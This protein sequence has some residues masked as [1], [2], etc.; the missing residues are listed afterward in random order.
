MRF[1]HSDRTTMVRLLN[2]NIWQS[3]RKAQRNWNSAS[4]PRLAPIANARIFRTVYARFAGSLRILSGLI[5]MTTN[6]GFL[7][8]WQSTGCQRPQG[9]VVAPSSSPVS[10]TDG[11]T[12]PM[13]PPHPPRTRRRPCHHIFRPPP[14]APPYLPMAHH[15]FITDSCI[16]YFNITLTKT[17]H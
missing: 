6:K 13:P 4:K 7:S 15:G 11:R 16:Y 2:G 1:R 9:F 14:S 8:F 3:A 17:G 5:V 10:V 12:S